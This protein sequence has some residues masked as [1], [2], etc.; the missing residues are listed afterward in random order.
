ML[1]EISQCLSNFHQANL[2]L[3]ANGIEHMDLYDIHEREEE[4]IGVRKC[5]ER[6]KESC[7]IARRVTTTHNP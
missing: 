4:T 6:F 3:S 1:A 2:M 7:P 5:D